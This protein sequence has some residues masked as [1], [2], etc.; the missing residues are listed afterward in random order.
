MC[1]RDSFSDVRVGLNRP[2]LGLYE[3]QRLLG[4]LTSAR[5]SLGQRLGELRSRY[6]VAPEPSIVHLRWQD[7]AGQAR[8][9]TTDDLEQ[10]ISRVR[11]G[12]LAA[13]SGDA[14][15]IIE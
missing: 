11:A 15:V 7:V 9:Q 10:I 3:A 5:L 6:R 13:L 4:D 8:I 1:I 14:V 12:V 2:V